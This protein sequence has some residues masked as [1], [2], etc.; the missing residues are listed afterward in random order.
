MLT[1][2]DLFFR[3][4]A[5][6]S[7]KPLA[8]EIERAEGINMY[9]IYGKKFIDLVSGVT[10]SNIGHR[11]PAVLKAVEDQ[12]GKYMHLMVYGKYIQSPQV[13][14]AKHLADLL[15]ED[16]KTCYFVSSGSEAIEGAMK[17]AK[18]YTGRTE[19]IAFRNAYHGGTQGALSILGSETLKNA[20]RPLLPD[21]RFLTFNSFPDLDYISEKTAC[22]VTEPIQAEAGI[23]LPVP[24]FLQAL[25]DRCN[26]ASALLVYDEIQMAFGRTGRLFCLEHEQIVPDILCLAKS[27][28][29]GMPLG[30]F[31]SSREIM[32]SLACNPELGHI[33]TFGGHPVCCAAA[34]ANLEVLTAGDIIQQVQ[35][36]GELF[37]RLLKD[38]SLIKEIRYKGL[39]MAVE[40]ESE[41]MTNEVVHRLAENGLVV[42]QFLFRPAAFRIAPPLIIEENQIMEVCSVITM[43]LDKF[44]S[45]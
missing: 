19:I 17:L 15:P 38:H 9:D 33:T 30:A 13:K 39:M 24:G 21:I 22:V 7:R 25:R 11:H 42:D 31:I 43:V 6:P 12:L 36:K 29:G 14:L 2:R 23:I 32:G 18:R 34:I 45:K 1:Q 40:L 28:G 26:Q 35:A 27:M 20:F 37:Y 41:E 4:V 3:H 8:L 10:V 16:L 44:S 5:L